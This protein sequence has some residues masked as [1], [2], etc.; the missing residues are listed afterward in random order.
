MTQGKGILDTHNKGTRPYHR[1]AEI[2]STLCE[3]YFLIVRFAPWVFPSS[4]AKKR[5]CALLYIGI[6]LHKGNEF[7]RTAHS[8]QESA[9]VFGL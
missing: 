2:S 4:A 1:I 6:A 7:V 3:A 9:K 5:S 8:V